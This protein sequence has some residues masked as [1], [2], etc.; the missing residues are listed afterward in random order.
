MTQDTEK[1]SL[2]SFQGRGRTWTHTP[3]IHTCKH[4][5]TAELTHNCRK[6]LGTESATVIQ[7]LNFRLNAHLSK[8]TPGL[9]GNYLYIHL[10]YS[11]FSPESA[12]YLTKQI[13]YFSNFHELN[14]VICHQSKWITEKW[15]NSYWDMDFYLSE[16]LNPLLH[17]VLKRENPNSST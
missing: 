1:P 14:S 13:L 17:T 2:L 9:E 7:H 16:P 11:S 5:G 15:P 10:I 8:T 3:V 6:G 12:G 4:P